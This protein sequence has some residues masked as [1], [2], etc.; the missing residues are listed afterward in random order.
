MK[1]IDFTKAER[2]FTVAVL[3]KL[4]PEQWQA[5]TLCEGWNVED[6]A[7]HEIVREGLVAPIG[8]MIPRLHK[9]QDNAIKRVEAK[10]REY[11][12]AK[13]SKYPWYFPAKLN[14]AEYYIH[15]EDMLRGE[16]KMH[17]PEPTGEVAELLWGSLKGLARVKPKLVADLGN[18]TVRNTQTGEEIQLHSKEA[19]QNTILSGAPGELLLFFYGRRKAAKVKL[20]R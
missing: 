8:I 13:L 1:A 9:I 16:L 12:V 10:G 17:R 6:L 11:I 4:T 15:I 7:A 3:H 14:V 18:L 2:Q 5:S 20:E 19:T